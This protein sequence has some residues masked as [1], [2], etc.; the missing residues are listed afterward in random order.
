M[1]YGPAFFVILLGWSISWA[2][3]QAGG[4]VL[5]IALPSAKVSIK[6]PAMDLVKDGTILD[7]AEAAELAESGFDL[8]ELN[9]TANKMW[10]NMTHSLSD[11]AGRNYPAAEIGVRFLDI[12][13]DSVQTNTILNRVQS[14]E[15][16]GLYFQLGLSRFSQP[17]MMRAALLRRLGYFV[18]SPKYY[19]NLKVTFSDEA[20]K[21]DFLEQ[22]QMTV[23]SFADRKWIVSETMTTVVFASTTLI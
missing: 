8:S 5:S 11:S 13:S 21:K 19:K 1:H 14:Q 4:K 7:P 18:P 22:A 3:T 17:M 20:K 23:G 2:Q 6:K 16:P 15:N 9:P 10:Q 12:E